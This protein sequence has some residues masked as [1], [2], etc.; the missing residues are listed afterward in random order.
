L[1]E[2]ITYLIEHNHTLDDIY[3][4]YT[5]DQVWLFYE[6]SVIIGK[7][8][9]YEETVAFAHCMG[10]PLGGKEAVQAFNKFLKSLLPTEFRQ[11]VHQAEKQ[12]TIR[13]ARPDKVL[14]KL[15][16]PMPER[17]TPPKVKQKRPP[18]PTKD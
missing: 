10:L 15:G 4:K 8:K 11:K 13:K 16:I 1:G 17:P 2:V 12:E 3:N 7:K 14:G 5:L 18:I 6:K 9:Q